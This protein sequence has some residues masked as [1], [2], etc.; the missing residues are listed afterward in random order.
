MKNLLKRAKKDKIKWVKFQFSD[1][2]GFVKSFEKPVEKLEEALNDGLW[3]DGSSIEGVSRICE[4]DM[5][6]IPDKET[7]TKIP[8]QKHVARLYCDVYTPEGKPFEGDP[9]YILNFM[10][11]PR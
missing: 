6:L 3:F 9:R 7:Y 11:M 10:I 4:S 8:W 2:H 1:F 5:F